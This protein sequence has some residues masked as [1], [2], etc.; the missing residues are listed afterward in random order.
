MI[1]ANKEKYEATWEKDVINGN[2]S[3]TDS[4]GLRK[5]VNWYNG[6][7]VPLAD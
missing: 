6:I 5:N 3:Y 1:T 2:G 4:N 7:M